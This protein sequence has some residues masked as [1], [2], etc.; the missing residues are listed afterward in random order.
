MLLVIV[1][2]IAIFHYLVEI[3]AKKLE[4]HL[5]RAEPRLRGNTNNDNPIII[6]II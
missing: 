2:L 4:T 1:L 3:F 6:K 5:S